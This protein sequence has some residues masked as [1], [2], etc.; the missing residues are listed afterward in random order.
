MNFTYGLQRQYNVLRNYMVN[1]RPLEVFNDELWLK[2]N[3]ILKINWYF[4][5]EGLLGWNI[6]NVEFYKIE[7]EWG[8][9]LWHSPTST[10]P[11][12]N[13]PPTINYRTSKCGERTGVILL[14]TSAFRSKNYSDHSFKKRILK[15]AWK[16]IKNVFLFLQI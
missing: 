5:H 4:P 11:F 7:F 12:V 15:H 3:K 14:V 10:S 13:S 9:I 8:I 6:S 2:Y 1:T 16:V